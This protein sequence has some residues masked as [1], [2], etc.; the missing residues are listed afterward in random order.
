M[1]Y[2]YCDYEMPEF[3][4]EKMVTARVAHRCCECTST[5]LPSEQYELVT[6][7]WAGEMGVHKTCAECVKLRD[8][9]TAH[10]PCFCWA[11]ENLYEDATEILREYCHHVPGMAMEAGRMLVNMRRRLMAREEE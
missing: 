10:V 11:Y 7:K 9:V 6:G 1:S 5:I 8:Y 4:R 3:L 2:C